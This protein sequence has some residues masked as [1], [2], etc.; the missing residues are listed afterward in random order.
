MTIPAF[1]LARQIKNLNGELT[2]AINKVLDSQGF[3][4]GTFVAELEKELA[5][6]LGVKHVISCNSGTDALWMA[7]QVLGVKPGQI[8]ITTP[9]SFIASSTEVAA[10]GG[11]LVFIDIEHDTFNISP[12]LIQRWLEQNA[13][14][15][16]NK[17]IHKASGKEIVGLLPVDLF[18]QSADYNALKEIAEIWNLWIIEDCAQAIGA[19]YEGKKAGT[20]G[21][22]GCFSFYPT[23]NLGAYGDAG[24][25]VTNDDELAR[26]LL[27]QRNHGRAANYDYEC[28][29]INSRLDGI[30]AA[31]LSTKL[32]HLD[33]ANN[34]RRAIAK[35]YNEAFGNIWWLQVPEEIVGKHVYHQYCMIVKNDMRNQLEK[36]LSAQ[37]VATRIFYPKTLNSIDFLK[38]T[39][40]LETQTPVADAAANNII[41][42]PMWP[43]MTEA[44]I[45]HVINAVLM[46]DQAI[47]A[48]DNM[49]TTSAEN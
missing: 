11:E 47:T 13:M 41:A 23:K 29:G 27:L 19:E 3:V 28:L 45:N 14:M 37:G 7:A 26:K 39:P 8:I 2:T 33:A 20:L 30:Q 5:K 4:G 17:A 38:P 12:Q 35:K 36:H 6:Y 25:C 43:E 32:P 42:L 48:V 10:L 40:M 31:I 22:I 49:Q 1:S 24:C 34:T 21:D 18:G 16:G 9:F 44:E 46:L 15:Q